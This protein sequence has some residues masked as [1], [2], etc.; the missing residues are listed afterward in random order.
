LLLD[1]FIDQ[2]AH[3]GVL[4]DLE[5]P[6]LSGL[7]RRMIDFA[8]RTRK[9]NSCDFLNSIEDN[10]LSSIVA[11]WLKPRPEEDDLRPEVDGALTVHESLD[12]IRLRKLERRKVE[13]KE[14]MKKCPPGEDEYNL[15]AQ[16]LLS[17]GR[18]L[19]R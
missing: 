16:E 2:V 1:G 13:I 18:R 6:V 17:I 10:D 8:G 12:Y 15:L 5:D 11:K 14:R 9:F 3:S 4:K 19:H 7:A